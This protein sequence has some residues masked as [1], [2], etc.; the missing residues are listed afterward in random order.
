MAVL[1]AAVRA[2]QKSAA[3]QSFRPEPLTPACCG[4]A[5]AGCGAGV[6]VS[7]A[8]GGRLLQAVGVG[9]VRA[10]LKEAAE[11]AQAVAA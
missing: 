10:V 8:A 9:R 7:C 6:F 2:G 11:P 5:A 1:A 3:A 4:E